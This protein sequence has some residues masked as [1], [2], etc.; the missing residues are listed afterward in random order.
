MIIDPVC[1]T[2]LDDVD[3]PG[4]EEFNGRL[5]FFGSLECAQEFR[6]NPEKYVKGREYLGEPI[7]G[8]VDVEEPS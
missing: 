7:P 4:M 2:Q 8:S 6:K 5:Y 1:G 3:S